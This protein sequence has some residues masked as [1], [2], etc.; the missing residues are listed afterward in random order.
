[1]V[2]SSWSWL[3][4]FP[5]CGACILVSAAVSLPNTLATHVSSLGS[6]CTSA[7]GGPG[8][9]TKARRS[10]HVKEG[11]AGQAGGRAEFQAEATS[12]PLPSLFIASSIPGTLCVSCPSSSLPLGVGLLQT[13]GL[14]STTSGHCISCWSWPGA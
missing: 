14:L 1:M 5:F 6:N 10:Q 11:R 7:G 9:G 4:L 12:Q 2:T 8:E 3:Q 13:Q